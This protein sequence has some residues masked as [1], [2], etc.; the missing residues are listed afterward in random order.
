M[1]AHHRAIGAA[2][3]IAVLKHTMTQACLHIQAI[4]VSQCTFKVVPKAIHENRPF[5]I[6]L[7]CAAVY[8]S[9]PNLMHVLL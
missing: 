8:H 4:I 5:F 9:A 7:V 2:K 1:Q 6:A 3:M